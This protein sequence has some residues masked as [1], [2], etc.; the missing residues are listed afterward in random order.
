LLACLGCLPAWADCAPP[1]APP[2]PPNGV[3]ASREEMV[4]AMHAIQNYDAAVKAFQ[5]C[6]NRASSE[7]QK[8]AAQTAVDRLVILADRFNSELIAFKKKN[9]Q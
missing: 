5:D 2:Q 4:L 9:S 1:Q 7:I 3:T 6:A 8:E